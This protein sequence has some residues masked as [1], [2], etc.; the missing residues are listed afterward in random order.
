MA[1]YRDIFLNLATSDTKD[2]LDHEKTRKIMLVNLYSSVGI[3]FMLLLGI[4]DFYQEK[5]TLA[6]V[7]FS[8][9][10]IFVFFFFY[11]RRTK[12]HI[13]PGYSVIVL[14]LCLSVYLLYDG[15]FDKS[16]FVWFY[17]LPPT[18]FFIIGRRVGLFL[19][20]ASLCLAAIVVYILPEIDSFRQSICEYAPGVKFRFIASYIAV[21]ILSYV[22]ESTRERSYRFK[23]EANKKVQHLLE[24]SEKSQAELE[25][26]KSKLQEINKE[27]EK[28]SIVASET[29]NAVTI[30]TVEGIIE[31]VNDGFT[32]LYGYTFDEYIAAKGANI[33]KAN[34]HSD[35]LEAFIEC[36]GSRMPVIYSSQGET[37]EGK[38]IWVQTTL[39]PAYN[40]DGS[41]KKLVIIDTDITKIKEAEEE[42]QQQKEE[43]KQQNEELKS[44]RDYLED[45]NKELEKL[46]IVAR[47]TDNSVIIADNE[48]YIE[49][50]NEGFCKLWGFT[51]EEYVKQRGNNILDHKN[52]KH[53]SD[54]IN[55]C[56]ENK[57]SVVYVFPATNKYGI[58]IWIQTTLTPIMNS[59]QQIVKLVAIEAE[60]TDIKEAEEEIRQQNEEIKQQNEEISSQRDSLD[61]MYK[62]LNQQNE[63][64]KD[65]IQYAKL[66]QDAILPRHEDISK[67]NPDHFIFYRPKAVVSGDFYWFYG[68][69]DRFIAAIADCTGHGV[70]GALMSMIGNTILN[71]IVKE[72]KIFT[73]SVILEK[74]NKAIK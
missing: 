35:F 25:T 65:S 45:V 10:S 42:I 74:M 7:L 21:A 70:P 31:W 22:F 1:R 8:F 38:K 49:W 30:A 56:I 11:M 13:F 69:D 58:S 46:S 26:Q 51:K 53:V 48:G 73:P 20:L 6:I 37:K 3:F 2:S 39:T 47:E 4:M 44:Q 18:A 33:I 23:E 50:V 19:I 62:E 72:E 29:D 43:I 41:V 60:I 59:S 17:V 54:L 68:D 40:K 67:H 64:L 5:I 36:L 15:G 32:K 27:L 28:L 16:G 63:L 12:D 71:Q 14:M 24:D 34:A 57:R 52:N 66:I 55:D 9:A 61:F